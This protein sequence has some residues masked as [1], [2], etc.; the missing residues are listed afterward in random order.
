MSKRI[1]GYE[2]WLYISRLESFN[3][4]N[5][6]GYHDYWGGTH[7]YK[8][9]SYGTVIAEWKEGVWY[10]ND[11]SYSISTSRHQGYVYHGLTISQIRDWSIH[12]YHVP[13]YTQDLSPLVIG[14]V[15]VERLDRIKS[16]D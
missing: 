11:T 8:V 7:S 10:L 3:A 14:A 1:A 13:W 2:S 5:V 15:A 16:C 9:K 4:G 6:I 12:L